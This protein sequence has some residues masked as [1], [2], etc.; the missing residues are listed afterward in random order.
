MS[1]RNNMRRK[2]LEP[3]ARN[4]AERMEAAGFNQ[5]RLAASIGVTPTAVRFWVGAKRE[6]HMRYFMRICA[7]LGCTPYE[8]SKGCR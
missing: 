6:P 7:V 2:E 1:D 4:L 8:L 3:F 5:R